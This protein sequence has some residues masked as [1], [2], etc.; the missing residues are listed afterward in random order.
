M[1]DV[2]PVILEELERLSPLDLDERGDWQAVVAQAHP[3]ARPHG[4]PA[5]RHRRRLL[6]LATS[7]AA[8]VSVA[9]IAVTS[10][11]L[12]SAGPGG[13]LG[14]TQ[15]QFHGRTYTL[16]VDAEAQGRYFT[17]L[18]ALKGK[19]DE[20]PHL[21]EVAPGLFT[22]AVAS[23][24]SLLY[25]PGMPQKLLPHPPA[26]TGPPFGAANYDS[27]GG[28]VWFGDSRPDIRRVVVTDTHGQT[29]TT[30]TV[31]PPARWK[32]AFRF[33]GVALPHSTGDLIA[34]YDAHGHL[35]LRRSIWGLRSAMH[36][37]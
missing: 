14:Q 12:W 8:L 28:Q 18:L 2:E 30:Q 36:L 35:V 25:V 7:V 16:Y 24:T 22:V 11:W 5:L 13:V 31:A 19:A 10:G 3:A 23:G 27:G 32:L 17:M 33:W 6:A 37:G 20:F 21:V 9:A 34:G 4:R 26:P 29:F 1:L 15:I